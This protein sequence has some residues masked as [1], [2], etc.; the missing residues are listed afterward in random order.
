[1]VGAIS[2]GDGAK[3]KAPT[4]NSYFVPSQSD[5]IGDLSNFPLQGCL[6][7]PDYHRATENGVSE[8]ES[9]RRNIVYD[10]CKGRNPKRKISMKDQDALIV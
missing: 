7:P 8:S 3:P 6:L 9:G 10:T 2:V 4:R 1:V 5:R